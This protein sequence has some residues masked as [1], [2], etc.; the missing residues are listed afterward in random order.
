MTQR[1]DKFIQA[2]FRKEAEQLL[3]GTGT[4]VRIRKGTRER[5]IL[6]K[7]VRTEQILKL[8]IPIAKEQGTDLQMDGVVEFVYASPYGRVKVHSTR[9]GGRMKSVITPAR[10]PAAGFSE[11]HLSLVDEPAP[12]P[13]YE[14]SVEDAPLDLQIER[15]THEAEEPAGLDAEIPRP[16]SVPRPPPPRPSPGSAAALAETTPMARGASH[17]ATPPP[18]V[19]LVERAPGQPAGIDKIL[20]QLAERGGSDLHLTAGHQPRIRKDGQMI[21]MDGWGDLTSEQIENWMMEVAHEAAQESFNQTNDADFAYEIEGV[22]RFRMN[23]FRDRYGVGAVMRTIPAKILT[24]DQ[25]KL[26][27]VIRSFCDLPKGLVVVTG[28]TGSGKSTTLAA[29]VDL[30]NKTRHDHIITVEDPVEFVHQSQRCLVNQRE[31]HTHTKSFS[32]ALRAALREDPDIVLVGEMRDLET[33]EI[34][35]ETAE[36]GHLVFGT[37]HTTTAA[38]TVDRIIDQFPADRQAQIRTML[39][40]SLKGVIAQTLCK[41]KPKGRLAALE[42]L[43]VNNAVSSQIREGKTHQIRNVMQTGGKYGMQMLNDALFEF[44]REG[45]VDPGEAYMKSVEKDDMRTKLRGIGVDVDNLFGAGD[46]S[47]PAGGGSAAGSGGGMRM[48]QRPAEPASRSTPQ[49]RPLGGNSSD[50]QPQA[51]L[52]SRQPE[53]QPEAPPE[54]SVPNPFDAFKKKRNG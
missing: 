19:R 47:A 8:L 53:P 31:V 48:Q 17:V 26:P 28:P 22:A 39:A 38:S 45:L 43:I 15:N 51:P 40:T 20:S 37:L 12:G 46:D 34:A 35:I 50:D 44:V 25:L 7:D 2:M 36:T 32:S 5:I 9:A 6:E 21:L 14:V 23:M 41:K 10:E 33:I 16:S 30:I 1:I 11:T 52:P 54:R 24:A 29:M 49:E 4:P 3:F 13:S 27:P 18:P 42:V